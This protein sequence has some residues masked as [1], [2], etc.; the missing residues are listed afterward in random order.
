MGVWDVNGTGIKPWDMK[1]SWSIPLMLW[2]SSR[3]NYDNL[4]IS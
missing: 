3:P 1:E 2:Q 4:G